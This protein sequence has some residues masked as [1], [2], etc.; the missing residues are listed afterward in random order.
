MVAVE[1]LPQQFVDDRNGA[2][3]SRDD[4]LLVLTNMTLL[5]V[6]IHLNTSAEGQIW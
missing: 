3:V 4:L 2:Q 1:I 5:L 6:R